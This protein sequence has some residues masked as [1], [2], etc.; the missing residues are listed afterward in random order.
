MPKRRADLH[1]RDTLDEDRSTI[2]LGAN[3][4]LGD[5]VLRAKHALAAHGERLLAALD[6]P[7]AR[8][9]V[10]PLECLDDLRKRDPLRHQTRAIDVDM[11]LL[12]ITPHGVDFNDPGDPAKFGD[13]LPIEERPELH[14]RVM[15]APNKE[16]MDL[17]ETGAH[18]CKF[19]RG[20]IRWELD[21]AKSFENE[22]SRKPDIRSVLEDD[23][24]DREPTPRHAALFDRPRSAVQG[25]FDRHCDHALHLDRR[26][27]RGGRDDAHLNGRRIWEGIDREASHRHIAR[28]EQNDEE[29]KDDRATADRKDNGLTKHPLLPKQ[30]ALQRENAGRYNAVFGR[31]P[32]DHLL[33]IIVALTQ[34]DA[35]D[36]HR[37]LTVRDENGGLSVDDCHG[38]A[39]Y[40][41][42]RGTG[43]ARRE[44]LRGHGLTRDELPLA[45]IHLNAHI[46][47]SRFRMD[48]GP[49]MRDPAVDGDLGIAEQLERDLIADA[50]ASKVLL[51]NGELD[52][53]MIEVC[54]TEGHVVGDNRL[55]RR[56]IAI[57]DCA[58]DGRAEKMPP[59]HGAAIVRIPAKRKNP[60]LCRFEKRV[61]FGELRLRDLELASG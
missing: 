54:D 2:G 37:V 49:D 10:R 50:D 1:I 47:A 56:D 60:L 34:S 18:R 17:P 57:D 5:L 23:R 16:L 8:T 27:P 43:V 30:L 55:S 41:E 31:E 36:P 3:D 42:N 6:I 53:E 29:H 14:R 9:E 4:D 13:D 52:P 58:V 45:V 38:R 28:E 44:D 61:V 20:R 11:E 48:L 32:L 35:R 51:I 24:D 39:R 46:G 7:A 33:L 25:V 19:G 59:H 26:E 12:E 40:D 15:I 21:P 22:L